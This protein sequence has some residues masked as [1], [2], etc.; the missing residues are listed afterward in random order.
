MVLTD[1]PKSAPPWHARPVADI[2]AELGVD[3]L[4]GLSQTAAADR[5][6]RFGP[7]AIRERQQRGPLRTFVGQFTDVMILVLIGAAVV[8][9][10]VGDIKDTLAILAIILLNALIGFVQEYRAQRAIAALKQLA[11]AT[12]T[13][14]RERERQTLPANELVPGD[15][16]LVEAGNVVPADLRLIEAT[17]LKLGE[18]AL[19]GESVPVTKQAAPLA[20]AAQ[21]LGDRRNMAFKGT[22][23]TYGRGRGL[24]VAT[25]M[26]TELGKIAETLAGA[27]DV[28]TPLQLRLASSAAVWC[29]PRWPSAW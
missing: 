3:L 27:D 8:S 23:V 13:V 17:Q 28:R 21:P 2:A 22:I 20:D 25:G 19:T 26:S 6:I 11:A 15:I 7:N 29:W 18:A 4:T 24:V 5:H 14:L 16:V 12:A 9:G 1:T 10:L